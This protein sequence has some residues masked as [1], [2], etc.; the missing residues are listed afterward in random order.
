M[1]LGLI[2]C[3]LFGALI[4]PTDPIAVLPI[5]RRM[6]APRRLASEIAG[7]SLFND[8][9]GVVV[10]VVLLHVAAGGHDVTAGEALLLLAR[11]AAGG[12]AF[13][14]L[15]G[16]VGYLLLRSL[17]NYPV[18]LLITLAMVSGGYAL[19]WELDIS[20]PL[21]MVVAGL[22]IGN[23]GR[24]FAMSE[25]TR[26][27][28][29]H[30]WELVEMVLNAVL[31]VLIGLEVLA[32]ME[33]FSMRRLAAGLIA[34]PLVLAARLVAVAGPVR[35]LRLFRPFPRRAIGV[36]TWAGLRGGIPVALALSLPPGRGS[37]GHTV[38]APRDLIVVMTYVVVVFSI[39]VQGST[40][41][42]LV[43]RIPPDGD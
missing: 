36:I 42:H 27:H 40:I 12:L 17:D 7:E 13:G 15:L 20:G 31:F 2:W 16:Y 30:F 10:F 38:G 22:L 33:G 25:L 26:E 23:H 18:E 9:I 24:R 34:V 43:R 41:K 29:D 8:G 3:L 11:E 19:A 21:A 6:N 1:D 5:L 4:S 39:L 35:V 37:A 14:L 32:L 28:L